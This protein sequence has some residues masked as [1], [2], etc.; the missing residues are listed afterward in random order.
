LVS[1]HQRPTD[2]HDSSLAASGSE[3]RSRARAL[4]ISPQLVICD[5]PVSALDLSVQA[6]VLNLLLTLQQELSL[7]YLFIAHDL[8]VVRHV[9]RRIAV[10]YHGRI[11]E[12]GDA[13]TVYGT[14][15]HPYTVTLLAAN[16]IPDPREQR[17]KRFQLATRKPARPE[18]Q[19]VTGCPFAARCPLTVDICI[20][21][22]P[23]LI[24]GPTGALVACHRRDE[25]H[26]LIRD[27][28]IEA[29]LPGESM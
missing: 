22:T 27:G 10:M 17:R 8:A 1:T 25:G 11:M 20:S 26:S 12:S 13:E 7:S 28:A 16:P 2:I 19:T 6:Q 4:I 23:E 9:S 15:S 14:P 24:P 3:S 29:Q 18:A 21:E 5:E